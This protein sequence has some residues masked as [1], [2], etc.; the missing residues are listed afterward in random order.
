MKEERKRILDMVQEGK[1]TVDEAL[2]LLEELEKS[3]KVMEEKHEKLVNDL[4]TVVQFEESKKEKSTQDSFQ[5]TKEWIFDFVDAAVKKLK[6]LDLDF[7]FGKSLDISHIFQQ[8]DVNVKQIDIDIANGNVTVIP[9]D[10]NDIRVECTAKVYR[11]DTMEEAKTNFL[12][13]VSFEVQGDILRFSTRQKWI[14]LETV[15]HVP[16]KEYD[17]VNIRLFNGGIGGA[18][19]SVKQFR[20][21]TANGKIALDNMNSEV[22]EVETANGS[23]QLNQGK[24]G[25]LDAE[26]LNG[27]I[28]VDGDFRK[29]ELQ[30]FNGHIHCKLNGAHCEVVEAKSTTGGIDIDVPEF[31]TVNGKL[32]SNLGNFIVDLEG[33]Q[34]VEEKNEF[35]QKT[36]SFKSIKDSQSAIQLLADTKTGSIGIHKA[37]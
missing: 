24:I 31:V 7:N 2:I 14:K 33:I 4:S 27:T 3:S 19:L 34:I 32:K 17:K 15:I 23:I 25:E 6:E 5:S 35:M 22:V 12:K 9:W 37:K 29:V 13:E 20:M 16:D 18:N 10:Q 36:F 8:T 28:L 30:S 1:L 26:T 11:F 21:K